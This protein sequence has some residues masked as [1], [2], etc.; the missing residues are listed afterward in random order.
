MN[1]AEL[2][3]HHQLENTVN[4]RNKYGY[5]NCYDSYR[6]RNGKK[7]TQWRDTTHLKTELKKLKSAGHKC[8]A[9]S[10]GNGMY[11]V[12]KLES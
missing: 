6:I 5:K 1:L 4:T 10:I 8:F 11:R 2:I 12:F 3:R 7:Y 9:V